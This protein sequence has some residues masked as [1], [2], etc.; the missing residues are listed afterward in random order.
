M[1]LN[2][3]KLN[4]SLKQISCT[5]CI[6]L[7]ETC[8]Y[9]ICMIWDMNEWCHTV[10]VSVYVPS[11]NIFQVRVW[12]VSIWLIVAVKRV[13]AEISQIIWRR[14][15]ERDGSRSSILCSWQRGEGPWE[16]EGERRKV[17]HLLVSEKPLEKE[18]E[19]GMTVFNTQNSWAVH[20]SFRQAK[21]QDVK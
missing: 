21:C 1:L 16:N 6:C 3:G 17:G 15:M 10:Y 13:P 4:F 18:R 5:S 2:G 7:G 11:L 9:D 8:V 20:A 14:R 19:R 12:H